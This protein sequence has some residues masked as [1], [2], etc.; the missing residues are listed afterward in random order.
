MKAAVTLAERGHKVTLVEKG[1]RLGGQVNLILKTP[2]R[3]GFHYITTD[4]ENKLK[5]LGVD[6][7][8]NTEAT[9]SLIQSIN[10]DGVILATGSVP[11][12][13]GFSVINPLVS[14]LPGHD[15]KNVVTAYEVLEDIDSIG[16]RVLLLDDDGTRYPA[17]IAEVLIKS[18]RDVTIVTRYSSLF[19]R[20]TQTLDLPVIYRQLFNDD[21]QYHLNSWVKEIDGDSANTYNIYT[22]KESKMGEFDTFVLITGHVTD[23]K[24]YQSLNDKQNNLHRIG[25]CLAPRRI[26]HAIYEGYLAG[27]ERFDNRT[28]YI[29]PGSLE[30][31]ESATN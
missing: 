4:L 8:F 3:E 17:G 21:I 15:Q 18:G 16:Q 28:K 7:R 26:D 25:D 2:R 23:D 20:M 24:L 30:N 14:E 11:D 27:L 29:E 9:E 1:D 13:T 10:P 5:K 31:F 19:P 22:G 6:V 12:R